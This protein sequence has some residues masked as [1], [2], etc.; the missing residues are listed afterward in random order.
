MYYLST[1]QLQIN[2]INTIY[3]VFNILAIWE[4]SSD[5]KCGTL[6]LVSPINLK[7]YIEPTIQ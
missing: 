7:N 2:T 3:K 1:W 6:L 4:K 5:F